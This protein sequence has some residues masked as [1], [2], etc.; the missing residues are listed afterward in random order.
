MI[1]LSGHTHVDLRDNVIYRKA[2]SRACHMLHILALSGST[3]LSRDKAGRR[4]LDRT[5]YGDAA[6]GYI[7]DVYEDKVVFKGIDF[8]HDRIYPEYVYSI[9]Q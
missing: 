8:L 5:F 3:R 9:Y 1:W 4:T 6:Q 7:A 2:D